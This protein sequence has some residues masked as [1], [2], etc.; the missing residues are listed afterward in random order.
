[1]EQKFLKRIF[2]ELMKRPKYLA[3]G[4]S[5]GVRLS[6]GLGDDQRGETSLTLEPHKSKPEY[7]TAWYGDWLDENGSYLTAS[8]S[9]PITCQWLILELMSKLKENGGELLILKRS[10]RPLGDRLLDKWLEIVDNL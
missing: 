3:P 4:L 2:D 6:F 9:Y 10:P 7:I 5:S 8:Q 1:M